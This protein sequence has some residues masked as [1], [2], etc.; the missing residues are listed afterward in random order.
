MLQLCIAGTRHTAPL[1]P[2]AG[3]VVPGSGLWEKCDPGLWQRSPSTREKLQC[4]LQW[5]Q[6]SRS[7]WR[8]YSLLSHLLPILLPFAFASAARLMLTETS[9]PQHFR[10]LVQFTYPYYWNSSLILTNP[11]ILRKHRLKAILFS[12]FHKPH[13]FQKAYFRFEIWNMWV[14]LLQTLAL[15][16]S[17]AF[18]PGLFRLVEVKL[19]SHTSDLLVF[20]SLSNFVSA[21]IALQ[22]CFGSGE[23][24]YANKNIHS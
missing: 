19:L 23:M 8:M 6:G 13:L 12:H 22:C 2:A 18:L 7:P 17:K 1:C 14:S 10:R 9:E 20:L 4:K 5:S 11:P 15:I 16:K 24:A 21:N 3:P